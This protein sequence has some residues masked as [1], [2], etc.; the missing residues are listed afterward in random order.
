MRSSNLPVHCEQCRVVTADRLILDG[1][2]QRPEPMVPHKSVDAFLLIHGTGSNFA[3]PGVLEAFAAGMLASGLPVLRVNT[4]GHDCVASIPVD[5]GGARQ[6]GAT[7]EVIDECRHDITAWL[8][9]LAAQGFSRIAL[10]GHSMGAVKAVYSQARQPHPNVRVMVAISPPRFCHANF[11][12][13]PRADEFRQGFARA[14]R[15]V[16]EARGEAL[17][18]VKQPLPLEITAAGFVA[19]YG[20]HDDYDILRYLPLLKVPTLVLVGDESV[21]S[22]PAFDGLPEELARIASEHEWLAFRL[23][24]GA[25]TKY[26]ACIN[27]PCAIA[28]EWL[29]HHSQ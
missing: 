13:H 5:G 28:A 17:M 3:A 1:V 4:R 8:D 15:L 7:Y 26:R 23:V 12:A 22:S 18:S 11:M 10:V 2:L 14:T 27:A 9:F 16:A 21:T 29:N 24:P 25:D 19:K 20:P 6:G